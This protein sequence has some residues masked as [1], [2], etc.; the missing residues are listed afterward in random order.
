MNIAFAASEIFP[1]AKTG[2]LGD[3]SGALPKALRNLGHQV[4][5]FMP[6]YNTINHAKYFINYC[7]D[8]GAINVRLGN[9]VHEVH[10]HMTHLPDSDIEIYFIDKPYY[11]HRD[12]IYTNDSDE[13]ERFILFQ[14]SVIE[15]L[16][17]LQFRPDIFHCNDWQTGLIPL[18]LKDNYS[19]DRMFDNT[20][21][22]LTIHNIGYQGRFSKSALLKAEINPDLFYENSPVETW[23]SANFLKAGLMFADAINTVSETYAKEIMTSEF[24][25]GLE[26]VLQFR[27]N[28][29]RGI[30]NGVD[31][32]VWNPANDKLIPHHYTA[33][34]KSNKYE[35]KKHLL[36]SMHLPERENVP[37]IGI[38]SRMVAQ[39]GFSL[40]AEAIYDLMNADAQWVILGSGETKLENLF[41]SVANAFPHKVAVH[42]GY[43]DALSHLIEAGADMFLMPSLYEPC[44]LN[45][46]YSLK[47]GTVPIVRNTGGLADTVLDWNY[48]LHQGL[49][50]G[51][52]FSFND[53][54]ADALSETVLRAIKTYHYKDAWNKI[55]R[56]GMSKDYSWEVSAK[57]YIDLY[58]HALWKRNNG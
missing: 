25:A 22:V 11:Y 26:G 15:I 50:I 56:N 34:D 28:D 45:Q 43:N 30:V 24:G 29:F 23:G 10:A 17:R 57:K 58:N 2:G 49:E 27:R 32:N 55:I 7:H 35:N 5:V 31:Y 53:S 4:K 18:F 40:F 9:V 48:Y 37:L 41:K 39:K 16:Q 21:S 46:I 52:G 51:T 44:G 20:A 54:S 6:N 14:K 19:W 36:R 13:D 12:K 33:E 3:V 47:Y 8:I 1:F 38:V 42:I